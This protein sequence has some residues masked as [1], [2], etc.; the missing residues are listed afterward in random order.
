MKDCLDLRPL[1][2]NIVT[3]SL[4]KQL[5]HQTS[6]RSD[7]LIATEPGEPAL[8]DKNASRLAMK[9]IAEISR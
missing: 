6:L 4:H 8:S 5:L 2:P 3:P 9:S 7:L 1:P